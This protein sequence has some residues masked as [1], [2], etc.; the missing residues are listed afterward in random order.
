[1]KVKW[2]REKVESVENNLGP[3]K[4]HTK[5]KILIVTL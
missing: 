2:M 4:V 3:I 5:V 1:M